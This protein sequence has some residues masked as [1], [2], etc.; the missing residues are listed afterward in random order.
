MAKAYD[1]VILGSGNAAAG[2]ARSAGKSVAII[3]EWDVA[4][5]CVAGL[6]PEKV[7]VAAAKTLR[8]IAIAAEHHISVGPGHR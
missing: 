1:F 2:V 5:L 3:E 8:T 6:R 4:D 7:F